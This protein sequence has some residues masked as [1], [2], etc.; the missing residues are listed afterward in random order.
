MQLVTRFSHSF[1]R[2]LDS[3]RYDKTRL[4]TTSIANVMNVILISGRQQTWHAILPLSQWRF[5][6]PEI[7]P[8]SCESDCRIHLSGDVAKTSTTRKENEST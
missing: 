2:Q 6:C 3:A 4:T 5:G 8:V 7:C 1:A